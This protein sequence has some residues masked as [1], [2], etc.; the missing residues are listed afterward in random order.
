MI[1]TIDASVEAYGHPDECSEPAEGSVVKESDS[2]LTVTNSNN[3][4]K[5]V[6][7]VNTADINVPSHAHSYNSLLGCHDNSSHTLDPEENYTSLSYNGS[8][9]Y[10]T[11][12]NVATDPQSGGRIA[13]T[14]TG[15]SNSLGGSNE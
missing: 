7:S 15:I 13:I 6:A 2:S 8:P 5:Q 10:I 14:N 12:D 1:V 4:T 9:L 11:G 3:E